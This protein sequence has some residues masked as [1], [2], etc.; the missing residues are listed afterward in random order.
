ML[1]LGNILTQE[2]FSDND[3]L[4]IVSDKKD[5]IDGIPTLVIGW[6]FTVSLY[7]ETSI[8]DWKIDDNTYWTFGK[9]ERRDRYERDITN[10]KRLI[11][12]AVEERVKYSFFNILVEDSDTKKDL[13]SRLRDDSKKVALLSGSMVYIYI[14]DIGECIG[15]SL[16][17]IEYEGRSIKSFLGMLYNNPSINVIKE[18]DVISQNNR[19]FF[20]YRKYLI[21][22]LAD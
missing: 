17:Q 22:C 16:E 7:P 5:L 6:D 8:I 18:K 11:F 12:D 9:R 21:P 3:Y 15:I 13:I 1:Y 19:E 4:N 20:Y 10:F 14:S 2:S